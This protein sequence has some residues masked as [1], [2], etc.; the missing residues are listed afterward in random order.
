MSAIQNTQAVTPSNQRTSGAML[1][2]L[3]VRILNLLSSVR[4][5]IVLLIILTLACMSG[6]LIMQQSVEGFDKYFAELTPAQRLVYG[7]LGFFDI[8]HT[9][10][11]NV[12]LMTLSLNIVLASIDRF[13]GAWK[14][15]TSKKLEASRPYILKQKQNA[16][17]SVE[18]ENQQSVASKVGQGFLAAGFKP[19]LTDKQDQTFLFGERGVWNRLGAY[20][21]HVALLTIFLGFFLTA[22]LGHTGQMALAPGTSSSEI[23]QLSFKLDQ[24]SNVTVPVPF[25][26]TCTDIQQ[27]L[28]SKDG[29]ISAMNTTDWLTR[30]VIRDETGEHEGLVHL[31]APFD[32]RGYRFFQSSFIA[33]G[34]ARSVTLKLTPEAGGEPQTVKIG[35]D[36]SASLPDGTR[37]QY[38]NFFP[39]FVLNGGQPDTASD[40]YNKPAA[41][42]KV[43]TPGGQQKVMYAYAMDLPD[44]APVGAGF[45]G[46]KFK[47]ADFEK[48]PSAHILSVQHDPGRIPY[49][50]GGL[51]LVLTLCWVFF[52]AHQ[53]VW[54]VV[55]KSE[56]G[57]YNVILGGHSNRNQTAF[58]DRFNRLV[59]AIEIPGEA[60]QS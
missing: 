60:N 57:V 18:A 31:N 54:A 53:R 38:V 23:S 44:G 12:L 29:S 43:T 56:D 42:L 52:F 20:A 39:D 34:N 9:W 37:I 25:T 30:I 55:G 49:Y 40:D 1:A 45:G 17:I 41:Q 35:R 4:F 10:Y 51:L 21:V 2:A 32:Y 27:K 28:I 16:T 13:P 7:G 15:F 22:R 48:V 50:L 46:F 58:E 59:K 47:L 6:M 14:Y 24:V 36:S 33:T 5:G 8:Y 26:V 3:P 19:R 11:F